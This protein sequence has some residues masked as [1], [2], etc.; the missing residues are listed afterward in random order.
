[1]CIPSASAHRACGAVVAMS[2][3]GHVAAHASAVTATVSVSRTVVIVVVVVWVMV[4]A[5]VTP[6]VVPIRIPAPVGVIVGITPIPRIPV[7]AA[8]VRTVAPADIDAWVAVPVERVV[9]VGVDVVGVAAS[10]VVV[11]VAP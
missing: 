8:P 3:A 1:M 11:I 5:M 2:H 6:T 9:A 4:V 7:I 10:V